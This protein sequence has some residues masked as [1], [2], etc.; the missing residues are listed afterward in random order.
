[1]DIIYDSSLEQFVTDPTR[2]EN[3]LDLVFT[4]LPIFSET[5]VGPGMSDHEAVLFS[6]KVEAYVP[7]PLPSNQTIPGRLKSPA[8]IMLGNWLELFITLLRDF[9]EVVL[10][11]IAYC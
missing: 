8:K 2:N 5:S 11:S 7:C 6:V 10:M 3:I 9:H 4:S 1:M